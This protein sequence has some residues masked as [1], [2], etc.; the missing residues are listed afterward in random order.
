MAFIAG[1]MAQLVP[2]IVTEL[3]ADADPF[4][5]HIYAALAG[6]ERAMIGELARGLGQ[7]DAFTR[8]HRLW[9]R[10]R[11]REGKAHAMPCH[12]DLETYI[13]AYVRII[14]ALSVS[15]LIRTVT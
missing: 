14:G 6:K 1:L 10:L 15:H 13:A 5:I 11:G 3:G 2:L 7:R 12:H 9:V 8:N 4:M